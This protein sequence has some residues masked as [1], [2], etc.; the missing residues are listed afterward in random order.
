MSRIRIRKSQRVD[1]P[2]RTARKSQ[3][4]GAEQV[5]DRDEFQVNTS[6]G[7]TLTGKRGDYRVWDAA[8][9]ADEWIVEESLFAKTYEEFEPGRFRKTATV[10]VLEL[11]APAVVETLEG[12]VEGEPGEHLLARG[13]EGEYYLIPHDFFAR[14][15]RYVD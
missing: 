4:C 2:W 14:H 11:S 3:V 8:N 5:I 15:Y 6:W 7:A 13:A 12:D 9:P 10:D 1:G